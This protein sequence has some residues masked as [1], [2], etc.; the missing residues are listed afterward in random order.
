MTT[1]EP[2]TVYFLVTT[3]Q[4]KNS[5][6]Q[7]Q[8]A[9]SFVRNEYMWCNIAFLDHHGNQFIHIQ[10]YSNCSQGRHWLRAYGSW[11][12]SYLCNKCLWPLKFESCSWRG[13]LTKIWDEVCQRLATGRWFSPGTRASSTN[14]TDCYDITEIL[15][16]V[17][18]KHHKPTVSIFTNIRYL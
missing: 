6:L 13:V 4:I 2:C 11:I 5:L 17:V 12:Y 7:K 1:F 14:K 8:S 18:I 10:L 9:L 15:L 16:K 3:M